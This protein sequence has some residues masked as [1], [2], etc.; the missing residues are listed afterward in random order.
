MTT[1]YT[2]DDV[3]KHNTKD[4]CWIIINDNVLDV[5]KFL[6]DHPA[7]SYIILQYGGTDATLSFEEIGHSS[8][9]IDLLSDYI[10]SKI[11]RDKKDKS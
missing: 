8:S 6:D 2:V 1:L 9:A 10:I 5:T 7:G 11:K 4:D 3:S